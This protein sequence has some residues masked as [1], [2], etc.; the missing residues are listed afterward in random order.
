M[1]KQSLIEARKAI[2][3]ENIATDMTGMKAQLNRIEAMLK[4]KA[5]EKAEKDDKKPAT[6]KKVEKNPDPPKDESPEAETE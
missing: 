5:K 4:G 1:A 3:L 2:A 6:P